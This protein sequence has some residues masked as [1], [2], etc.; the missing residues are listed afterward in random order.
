MRVSK[1]ELTALLK[2]VFEGLD[3]A[4]GEYENAADMIV[5]AQMSGME[6]LQELRRALPDLVARRLRPLECISEDDTH[7]VF[8]AG[9]HSSL[10][11]ADVAMNLAYVKALAREFSSVTVLNCH[12]RKLLAKAVTDCG[13]RG[14]GCI[15]YWRDAND[16]TVEHVLSMPPETGTDG[17][18]RYVINKV[19]EHGNIDDAHRQ[20]LFI[21]CSTHWQKLEEYQSSVFTQKQEELTVI[22]PSVLRDNYRSA[23]NEGLAMEQDVWERLQELALIVL[24]ESSE[25]S[26]MGAGA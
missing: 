13:R 18:P 15:V 17:L 20:S 11:C 2:Q 7:A 3:F 4:S 1:T 14:I 24:V 8:D 9:N 21:H 25:Q 10:T 19:E 22:E 6:G 26:R 5:W 12:N 16:P 23:L